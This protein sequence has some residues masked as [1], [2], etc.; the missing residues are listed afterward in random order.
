[1]NENPELVE[2]RN[3]D[4]RHAAADRRGAFRGG[5]RAS[6]LAVAALV[7]AQ[8]AAVAPVQA[9]E[10]LAR[11]VVVR[12]GRRSTDLSVVKQRPML[13]APRFEGRLRFGTEMKSLARA[14]EA[15]M[16]FA[17]GVFWTGAW[18]QK[19]GWD[20]PRSDLR[21]ARRRGVVPV[22][23][24]WYWGDDISPRAVQNGVRDA[25][26][27]VHKDRETW[28][29][30]AGE[31]AD[32]VEKETKGEAM[33]VLET[34][35]NKGGIENYE[36]FDAD[37]A[38]QAR[39]FRSRGIKVVLGFGNWGA[40]RWGTFDRAVAASDLVGTQLLRSSLR[41]PTSYLRAVDTLVQGARALHDRFAKPVLIMDLALSSYPSA[42][43]EEHQA[44]VLRQLFAR[45]P[46][47]KGAGVQGLIWRAIVDDPRFDTSNYHGR[48]ERHW[49]VLRSDGSPKP[50]F[51][52]LRDGIRHETES[53]ARAAL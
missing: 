46:E 33:V 27:G 29:R 22:V 39:I 41:E 5:R 53:Q 14:Q 7:L 16:E 18:N 36:P 44:T 9:E 51:A 8:L 30:M 24:W 11:G 35:F 40:S 32:L 38:E 10:A 45:L 49:G 21:E 34:E 25:R 3:G 31:L 50:A 48:A 19:H 17:Y 47:L 2:R 28:F 15:G 43:Y 42:R 13:P 37:L 23:H 6:D 20:G 12:T 26:Q 1:M 52:V 4:R